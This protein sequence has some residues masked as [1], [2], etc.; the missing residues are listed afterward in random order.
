MS[1]G[2]AAFLVA[3]FSTIVVSLL[4]CLKRPR[5]KFWFIAAALVVP[6][7]LANGLYWPEA[8]QSNDPVV[9]ADYEM[10][11]PVCIVPWF[12]AGAIPSMIVVLFIRRTAPNA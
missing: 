4:S 12:L 5:G 1:M 8:L 3:L 11:A 10:W 7:V 2:S 6:F 9:F